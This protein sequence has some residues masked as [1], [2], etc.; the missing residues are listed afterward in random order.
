MA[1]SIST[2]PFI[3]GNG[4]NKYDNGRI[5]ITS[6]KNRKIPIRPINTAACVTPAQEYYH[7]TRDHNGIVYEMIIR[8]SLS[9]IHI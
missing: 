4:D 2:F 7:Q 3:L 8:E 6:Q 5:S 9:L 1:K